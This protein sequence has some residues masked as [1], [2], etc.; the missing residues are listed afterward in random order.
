M[1]NIDPRHTTK[2]IIY[3]V[4]ISLVIFLI[5]FSYQVFFKTAPIEIPFRI[6]TN[7][8]DS[9]TVIKPNF[10]KTQ[11]T[12]TLSN[13]II[14]KPTAYEN[15]IC[16]TEAIGAFHCLIAIFL[17]IP[18]LIVEIKLYNKGV[19][20][21]DISK[22]IMAAG[23]VILFAILLTYIQDYL[24]REFISNKLKYGTYHPKQDNIFSTQIPTFII[25]FFGFLSKTYKRAYDLKQQQDL[26]I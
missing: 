6:P 14:E 24:I 1:E 21:V 8:D 13:F 7:F 19:Y 18:W 4:S 16:K 17:L 26:T 5:A 12:D 11:V 25:I 23:Y 15:L 20:N 10:Y 22:I 9:V 3:V 2:G